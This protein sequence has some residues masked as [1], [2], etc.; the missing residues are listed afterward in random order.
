MTCNIM[1]NM[2]GNF[3]MKVVVLIW[4]EVVLVV[5]SEE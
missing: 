5:I 3:E 4:S 2:N 1:T